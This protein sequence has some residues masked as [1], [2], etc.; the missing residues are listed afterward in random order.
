[1]WGC[2]S[3]SHGVKLCPKA[4]RCENAEEPW[5][6]IKGRDFLDHVGDYKPFK[7]DCSAQ[8]TNIPEKKKL[9]YM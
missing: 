5:G 1:M 2:R 3:D 4:G 7:T 9:V 6:S 8:L